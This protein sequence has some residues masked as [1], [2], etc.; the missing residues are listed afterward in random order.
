MTSQLKTLN[1]LV[2]ALTLATLRND[3]EEPADLKAI[4]MG[5]VPI[6]VGGQFFSTW[7]FAWGLLR[8][9]PMGAWY[10]LVQFVDDNNYSDAQIVD[11]MKKLN[12]P[13]IPY[14]RYNGFI[15]MADFFD[16]AVALA[17]DANREDLRRLT[18]GFLRYFNRYTSWAIFYFD[19]KAGKH[20]TYDTPFVAASPK[21]DLQRQ[22]RIT[23]GQKIKLSW[24]KLGITA[25]A[26]LATKE[27]PALCE[28]F[29]K[30]LPFEALH[31]HV[32]VSGASSYVWAPMV[33]TVDTPVMERQCDAPLGRL[34]F[35]KA[36]GMKF[37]IQYGPVT[38]DVETPVLGEILPQYHS[39]LPRLGLNLWNSTYTTKEE[40][41]CKVELVEEDYE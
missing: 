39:L 37:I 2:G 28:A 34:R 3:K 26:Y 5:Q 8:D 14:M 17:K 10:P 40:I 25:Y 1:D 20:H 18:H 33:T 27:N 15:E 31:V 12:G 11:M 13:Y 32:L 22:V 29:T 7:E 9:L 23:N 4:R 21:L 19:W 38:E 6:G 16:A 41:N 24:E 36:T 30:A 35:S